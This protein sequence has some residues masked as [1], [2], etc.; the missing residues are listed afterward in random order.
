MRH[1]HL[2]NS[3]IE[4]VGSDPAASPN[5]PDAKDQKV[6][7]KAH[8]LVKQD[9]HVRARF[10][11]VDELG[12]IRTYE[13]AGMRKDEVDGVYF[14]PQYDIQ[15][16]SKAEK[17]QRKA[18]KKQRK[19]EEKKKLKEEKKQRKEEEKKRLKEEKKRLKEEKKKQK[20][21]QKEEPAES[22]GNAD[23]Q[24]VKAEKIKPELKEEL[25]KEEEENSGSNIVKLVPRYKLK[26]PNTQATVT[27]KVTND[28]QLRKRKE[29]WELIQR[30]YGGRARRLLEQYAKSTFEVL[31]GY[32]GVD[33]RD[34]VENSKV[35]AKQKKSKKSGDPAKQQKFKS[36]GEPATLEITDK[37]VLLCIG[38]PVAFPV[39]AKPIE[40]VLVT[41]CPDEDAGIKRNKHRA[42]RL[43]AKTKT[44]NEGKDEYHITKSILLARSQREMEL[45]VI[46]MHETKCRMDGESQ[47]T[48]KATTTHVQDSQGSA[49]EDR[50]QNAQDKFGDLLEN[51]AKILNEDKKPNANSD[52]D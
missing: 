27:M 43:L 2:Q 44:T 40:D 5:D 45:I 46:T 14:L 32:L 11:R 28:Q 49:H 18:E 35:P 36:I 3:V 50:S 19:E 33:I 16:R 47:E 17:K 48:S 8:V 41:P 23:E 34:D 13:S 31:I 20:K 1:K 52:S 21:K 26:W 29:D 39:F 37:G 4:D 6:V 25:G 12:F 24:E 9:G 42:F 30:E 22:G 7:S 51:V 38:W 10:I 15:A